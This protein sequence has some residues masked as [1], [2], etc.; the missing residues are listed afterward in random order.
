MTLLGLRYHGLLLLLPCF[1]QIS[2]D[3]GLKNV[4]IGS[5]LVKVYLLSMA[6]FSYEEK[7]ML[8]DP[9]GKL[10]PGHRF[11]G[12]Y[13]WLQHYKKLLIKVKR[14]TSNSFIDKRFRPLMNIQYIIV[15]IFITSSI[16]S[17]R[18]SDGKL[19]LLKNPLVV[20]INCL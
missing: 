17:K 11:L 4:K 1:H 7:A 8:R 16:H 13:M 9:T 2:E 20:V 15:L 19:S 5:I 6:I 12:H 18:W 3:T 14:D 10:H